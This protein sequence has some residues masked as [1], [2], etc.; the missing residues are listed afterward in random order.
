MIEREATKKL[1]KMLKLGIRKSKE[2]SYKKLCE[3]INTDLWG[4]PYEI[5][6][7]KFA[8]KSKCQLLNSV[9]VITKIVDGLFPDHGTLPWFEEESQE[10]NTM[11]HQKRTPV[12]SQKVTNRQIFRARRNPKRDPT[13]SRYWKTTRIP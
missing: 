10:D 11:F 1:R 8:E 6:M 7:W 12:S 4:K 3:E 2:E 9:G 13:S 5:I